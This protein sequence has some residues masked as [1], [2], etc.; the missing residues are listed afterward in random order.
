MHSMHVCTS[1]FCALC[2]CGGVGGGEVEPPTKFDTTLIFRGGLVEK[3]GGGMTFLEGR[4]GNFYI[5]NN[6]KSEIF[7]DK[8]SL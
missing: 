1:P 3:M 6:L 7:N 2:V 5:K 4:G 8:K